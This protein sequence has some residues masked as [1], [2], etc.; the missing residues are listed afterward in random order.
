MSDE[1]LGRLRLAASSV[2]FA[3]AVIAAGPVLAQTSIPPPQTFNP[4]DPNGVNL[5]TGGIQG[6]RHSLRIGQPG[7]G[8]LSI[9]VYYD[10][11]AGNGLWRHTQ[12]G[13]LNRDPLVP[14]SPGYDIPQYQLTLPGFSALYLRDVDGT[15]VLE[16]G[17]GT[18]EETSTDIFTY[19]A[20]DGTIATIDRTKRSTYGTLAWMGQ[21]VSIE[22]PNGEVLTYHYGQVLTGEPLPVYARRLQSV[23]NNLGYQIH[24][25]YASDTFGPDWTRIVTVTVLNNAVDWCD[26]LANNCTF[27]R[28]WPSLTIGGTSTDR[29][30]TDATG[31]T[32]HYLFSSGLLTGIRR[33]TQTTGTSIAYTR[34]TSP[35]HPNWVATASDGKGTWTYGYTPPPPVID[36]DPYYITATVADPTGGTMTAVNGSFYNGPAGRRTTRLVTVTDGAGDSTNWEWGGP[37][38]LVSSV[39]QEEGNRLDYGYTDRGDLQSVTRIPKP[40]SGLTPT[41]VTATFGDCSTPVACGRPTA[42]TDARGNTTNYTYDPTHGGLL[43]ETQP[44]PTLGADRPQTRYTYQSLTAW[45]RTSAST[46]QFQADPVVL[47]T[48][49]STCASGTAP[50]CVGTANEI[51]TTTTYQAGNATTGSNLLPVTVTAGAGNGSLLASTTTTWDANGDMKTV[52]GPLAGTAD[53]TWYAYDLMRRNVGII[54]PD[55]DGGGPL[56]YPATRTAYNADGQLAEVAQGSST[57]QSDV[58]LAA[59]TVLS[60][61]VTAYDAQARKARE[62]QVLGSGTLGVTQYAYDNE[63]RLRCT[64]VRMNPAAYGTLPDSACDLGAEGSF[65][66]DR[67]TRN[68]YDAADRLTVVES[69]VGTALEQ[70]T[71][72]QAWTDNDQLDWVED[73]NGNRSDYVYDGFDRLYRL[74]FPSPTLGA[75][76]AS[77][78]DYEQYGYDAGDN[79]TSRRLRDNQTI[80]YTYDSLNRQMVKTIPGGGTADDVFTAY[81]NLGRRL[82]VR[83]TNATTGDG[84][85]WT[86]DALGRPVAETAYGRTLTSAYDLA[87]HRTR[88]TWPDGVTWVSYQWDLADRMVFVEQSP[89][90]LQYIADYTYD[91]LGR[92]TAIN[93]GNGASTTWSYVPNSRDFSLTQNLSGTANDVTF[94]LAFNPAG[95]AIAR[96]TSNP[97]Y[98]YPMTAMTTAAY[99][100][101]GLNQYDSVAGATFTHDLRGN[102]TSDGVRT[103]VYDLENRLTSV[104]GGGASVTLAYDPLGRLRRVTTGGIATD[105]LWDG[106]RLVAE[107]NSTGSLIARYAH[108]PGPDEPLADWTNR[109]LPTFFHTDHQGTIIGLSGTGA[110]IIGTPYTYNPYGEPDAGHGFTG[111][112]F[113]YTGQTALASTVPLWH[114]KARAYNPSIGRFLQTDP[115]GYAESL[116][117]YQYVGND[118]FNATDPT[119]MVA[120]DPLKTLLKAGLLRPLR[121]AVRRAAIRQAWAMERRLYRETGRGTRDWTPS[122]GRELLRHGRVR[123]YEGHHRRSV[124]DYPSDAD[125][126]DNIE[127]LTADAHRDIHAGRTSGSS[128]LIDRTAGGLIPRPHPSPTQRL[129]RDLASGAYTTVQILALLDP[130]AALT[131]PNYGNLETLD[132]ALANDSRSCHPSVFIC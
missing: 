38:W 80:S 18:L 117:L 5:F 37:G 35:Y 102:L 125:N 11:S 76:T 17:T 56:P 54:A 123:G 42:I 53:T 72:T 68:T 75:H 111:P 36:A 59:M 110:A 4:V 81:D 129:W 65:G 58:A 97:A 13:T 121:E 108:G 61:V 57:A 107:Y 44:A 63:G 20:L 7:Q 55:P 98:E 126:P 8:G 124:A 128:E 41:T 92:R 43:T 109:E 99:V 6:P 31:N 47:P 3:L 62:D 66:P 50:S 19:T 82:S 71:R 10:S 95:Q 116:N 30:I 120:T 12:T 87:G 16:D 122:E 79:L 49:V 132:E 28:T 9:D 48:Q 60:K 51:R 24:F 32:T 88:L 115:I 69:A 27:S 29:T 26:P 25:Q 46:T 94:S 91:A 127:F 90:G 93:L 77:A 34:G 101:D 130:I 67:I 83:Y 85:V 114:Y 78:T 96:E 119:G 89:V 33:P 118:P 113:R 70:D 21:V 73:A 40:G 86:W 112:R 131:D 22:R 103:Y 104:T 84:V 2:G 100:P 105:W 14:G 106:D 74:Y 39:I 45:Y 15:F 64:A 23:T 1:T 52:D